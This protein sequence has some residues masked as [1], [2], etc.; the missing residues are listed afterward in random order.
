MSAVLEDA[1]DPDRGDGAV[2]SDPAVVVT[3]SRDDEHRLN[4]AVTEQV[5][6]LA[7]LGVHGDAHAGAT[8][9]HRS[10]V[11]ADPTQPNLRQVH[12][13][14]AELLAELRAQGFDVGPGQLGENILTAGVDLLGLPRGRRRRGQRGVSAGEASR[15]QHRD[16]KLTSDSGM[17]RIRLMTTV[18]AALLE[19]ARN[20]RSGTTDTAL[21]DEALA[22]LLGRYRG[23]ASTALP[24]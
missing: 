2:A 14:H 13:I 16:G 7:G 6:W 22:A 15:G 5:A 20:L 18:D 11:A 3:V 21:V 10:R 19:R 23:P 4:K 8:V 1:K 17:T 24:R 12:L 9:Q